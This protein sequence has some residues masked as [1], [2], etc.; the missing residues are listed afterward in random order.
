MNRL[1]GHIEFGPVA[2]GIYRGLL[3]AVVPLLLY[4]PGY[5]APYLLMLL[6]LGFGLKPL[7]EVT[8]LWVLWEKLESPFARRW[9]ARELE[10][11]RTEVEIKR[12][13][14]ALRNR[15]LRENN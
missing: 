2:A 5:V 11:H 15:R 10:K 1:R 12:R 4:F 14:K 13:Q 7:L 3:C 9:S 8:G 6:F